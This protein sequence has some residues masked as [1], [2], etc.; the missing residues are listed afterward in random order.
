MLINQLS[1]NNEENNAVSTI[2][3]SE[4]FTFTLYPNNTQINL[5]ECEKVLRKVYNIPSDEDLFIGELDYH[6]NNSSS[7]LKEYSVYDIRGKELDINICK[8]APIMI[9]SSILSYI[10]DINLEDAKHFYDEYGIN[11]F[12]TSE[13]IFIN[14]CSSFSFEGK[15]MTV[16]DRRD[17]LMKNISLCD[18]GCQLTNLNFNTN[19]FECGCFMN[20]NG[21][22]LST[23]SKRLSNNNDNYKKSNNFYLFSC[24]NIIIKF[25]IKLTNYANWF[26]IASLILMFIFLL[27]FKCIQLNQI[28]SFCYQ[29]TNYPTKYSIIQDKVVLSNTSKTENDKIYTT[30]EDTMTNNKINDN[31]TKYSISQ[32]FTEFSFEDAIK[33][34]KR[35]FWLFF[36]QSLKEKNIITSTI[37]N[38]SI[39]YPLSLRLIMLIFMI[40]AF[41][42]SNALFYTGKYISARFYEV[43]KISFACFIKQELPRTI[44]ASLL[45]IVFGKISLIITSIRKKFVNTLSKRNK[46]N[47]EYKIS[48]LLKILKTRIIL[49][50]ITVFLLLILFWYFLIIFCNIYQN[51]QLSLII[52]SLI[53]LLINLILVFIIS[54][55]FGLIRHC[56]LTIKNKIIYTIGNLTL[57]IL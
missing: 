32:M 5:G 4:T 45:C 49:F 8:D 35:S 9:S 24:Y 46:Q 51:T 36:I 52:S 25:Q 11:I 44:Y 14:Q 22:N 39:F 30:K 40:E 50:H 27:I 53:S 3:K 41:H 20:N 33:Y 37:M 28:F 16:S 23:S 17:L 31:M 7:N 18:E 10:D 2:I 48:Q 56:G 47:F 19:Q 38:D 12:N 43:D 15:D 42:F 13:E 6:Q 57:I 54:F 1:P 26:I 29:Y 34:D 55:I 21:S